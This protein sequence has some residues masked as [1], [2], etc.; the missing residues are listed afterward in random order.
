MNGFF[1]AGRPALTG[2]LET[3]SR[4]RWQA[5][6]HKNFERCCWLESAWSLSDKKHSVAMPRSPNAQIAVDLYNQLHQQYRWNAQTA[7]HGIAR[8][9]LSCEIWGR[10][11][12]AFH[13]VV[14]YRESNDFKTGRT[15]P[16][17]VIQ[18]AEALSNYLAQQ[19]GVDRA[20]LCNEIGIYWR[21]P[22]ISTLQPHNLVG[23]A[24][25]SLVVNVLS[26]FGDNGV[27]YEEEV[28]PY[29][30]F[31]GYTF[32]TRS[33]KPKF[34]IVGRRGTQ[35]VALLSSRW[36]FRHDRVDVVEEA[37]SYAPA[38]RRH[39]PNCRFYAVVGEFAPNRLEKILSNC[40]P[41][42][43]HAALSATVH[44]A[45]NLITEGLAENGRM[46][47]L[48]GLDWLAAETFRW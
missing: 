3:L 15:G 23:H 43:P 20:A 21:Q 30:E 6:S 16:N 1:L 38:A 41:A 36:R 19:L 4:P 8:L 28:D 35:I 37:M 26:T 17:L 27:A 31:P 25:R 42:I 47:H 32:T 40:P 10:G 34:D 13:N 29:R 39:N 2:R 48:K 22:R 46:A 12:E 7:W 45:P 18:R 11:W 9:L 5:L 14:V 24:Y 44:F 33:G